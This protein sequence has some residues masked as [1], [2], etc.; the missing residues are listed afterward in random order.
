MPYA[1][2]LR[3]FILAL[4]SASASVAAHAQDI[5]PRAFA[6]T[7]VGINFLIAGYAYT[8]GTLGT[9][10]SVPL[11]DTEVTSHTGVL[12]YVRSLDVWGRSGKIDV[13]LPYSRAIGSAESAG[14]KN[15]RDVSGLAD[16]RLRFSTL[17]YGGPALSLEEFRDYSPDWI[18]GVSLEASVPFSQYDSEK[19]LNVGT[20]RWSFKPS[21][22]IS[23]TMEP[24]TLELAAGVRFF[25]DND[26]FLG[27]KILEVSPVYS[28]QSHL[29]YS[30]APGF[31]V[32]LDGLYYAGAQPTID[33]RTG[34]SN[35]NA[36]VGLTI[37]LPVNISNSVK[38]YGS[39]GVYSKTGTDYDQIGVAW[40]YRW[41][42]GL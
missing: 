24:V 37:T 27:G 36:R 10:S 12:A 13:I 5:E 25:T 20:N 29:I 23:K 15:T 42:A 31:W 17:L 26:E 19:L 32:G 1:R 30:F 16:P 34:E 8:E 9:D 4:A 18:I 14:E 2:V 33:G 40:Q 3:W 38:V 28:V 6:N 21:I 22:G 39:T 7:P 41:G 35:E 11:E